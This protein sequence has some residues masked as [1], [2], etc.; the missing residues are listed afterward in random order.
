M[1]T[2]A[3]ISRRAVEEFLQTGALGSS[4]Q[5][6]MVAACDRLVRTETQRSADS[7]IALGRSFLTRAGQ[8]DDRARAIALRALGWALVVAGQYQEARK[9]YLAAREI[10]KKDAM[11]R[12]RIDRIL[13]DIYMYLN[14]FNEA[15]KRAGMALGTFRRLKAQADIAKTQVNFANL[16]HRMDRHRE[17]HRRYQ[18][19]AVYFEGTGAEVAVALCYYNQANTL[20]QLF[21]FERAIERYR[22]AHELFTRHG[23]QLHA[24]SCLYGLAWIHMLQGDF[25]RALIELN[26]C[27]TSY[28]QGGQRREVVLCRLDRA[29]AFLGLNLYQDALHDARRAITSA[30][31]LQIKYELAKGCFFGAQALSGLGRNAEARQM[32]KDAGRNFEAVRNEG[33]SAAVAL[34]E[35]RLDRSAKNRTLKMK[36][37]RRRFR[38]A[39]LPLWA[40]I[41]DLQIAS[42]TSDD[43][44]A[45]DRL[46]RNSAVHTVPHLLAGYHTLRGDRCAEADDLDRAIGHWSQAAEL[47]DAVRAKLPPVEM[48]SSFFATRSEPHRKLVESQAERE[49]LKAAVWS[50]RLK[51]TG[52]WSTLSDPADKPERQR[53]TE[54]LAQLADQ[55][56]SISGNLNDPSERGLSVRRRRSRRLLAMQRE[57]RDGLAAVEKAQGDISTFEQIAAGFAR[58]SYQ[59]PIVQFYVGPQDIVAFVHR[60]GEC[61]SY[62]YADGALTLRHLIGQWRY[63]VEC[64]PNRRGKLRRSELDDETR[65][66]SRIGHWLLPPLEIPAQSRRV[67]IIPEGQLSGLPWQALRGNGGTCLLDRHELVF[68]PSLR[69]YEFAREQNCRSQQARVFVGPVDGLRHV[70]DELDMVLDSLGDLSVQVADPCRREDWPESGS[71]RLWHYTG[72]ASLRTDNPFYSSLHL[73][74]GP[75][76]A[77]DFRLR[78][79]RVALVTLAACRTGQQAGLPAEESAGL[80]RALLEM[81]ARTVV[82]GN[83]AVADKSTSVWMSELY[84]NYI[85]GNKPAEAVRRSSLAVRERYPSAYHWG[86]FSAFGAD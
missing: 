64:V 27:E 77:A 58:R 69:H 17:A 22:S 42:Q 6:E 36:A 48:R 68:S 14:D 25:H 72:H 75:M 29:E 26:E 8:L 5:A 16:L 1:V 53:V 15:R 74:D 35:A 9:H 60:R 23:H 47:L 67:L 2:E 30:R 44:R 54:S 37:A 51:T 56:A 59:M 55:V 33:F 49:P 46:A 73:A 3:D 10:V 50:E 12:A 21:D 13:I 45:L 84:R 78:H 38:R 85:D 4:G 41:C 70:R 39:Q 19:A 65:I 28:L 62:R 40:A 66:L 57:V 79:N 81:G 24:T 83:W 80:V 43:D 11:A 76:F 71:Y 61:R 63:F 86:A 7:S 18:Q 31:D 82:A 20:V 52:L 34:T 32:L